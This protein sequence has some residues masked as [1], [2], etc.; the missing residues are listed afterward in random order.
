MR[1]LGLSLVLLVGCS[2]EN[3][4]FQLTDVG[5]AGPGPA[6]STGDPPPT[7]GATGDVPA[8]TSGP[9]TSVGGTTTTT[10]GE[11]TAAIDETTAT[12][13]SAHGETTQL[14]EPGSDSD[15]DSGGSST[16]QPDPS[17]SSSGDAE[18]GEPPPLCPVTMSL[19]PTRDVFDTMTMAPYACMQQQQPQKFI[20]AG[21]MIGGAL[22][23]TPGAGCD[24]NPLEHAL[25]FGKGYP[26]PDQPFCG[27]LHVYWAEGCTIGALYVKSTQN[28]KILYI[29]YYSP[30]EIEAFPEMPDVDLAG[31]C[32][33][34]DMGQNCCAY[35][36]GDHALSVE[37]TKVPAG[38]SA[39]V[40]ARDMTFFNFRTHMPPDCVDDLSVEIE[41]EYFAYHALP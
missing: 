32:G 38:G 10:A 23:F 25:Q 12:S 35:V 1:P 36:P 4:V 34:P 14:A 27:E 7:T 9:G 24:G 30:T 26:G 17:S 15:G 28:G 16:G 3:P 18:S 29:V 20:G 37:G 13:T 31:S 5:E 33:C 39:Y 19:G 22:G 41:Q 8:T 6:T 40:P 2:V 21:R 11:S